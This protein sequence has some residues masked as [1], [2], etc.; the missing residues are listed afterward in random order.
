MG[1]SMRPIRELVPLHPGSVDPRLSTSYE[2]SYHVTSGD[3]VQQILGPTQ[4]FNVRGPARDF[5]KGDSPVNDCAQAIALEIMAERF[6]ASFFQNGALPLLIF[7]FMEGTPGFES[8]EQ[9]KQF[10]EDFQKA[11]SGK[12]VHRGML[13]PKGFEKPETVAFEHDR[14]QFLETRQY[15]RTVIAGAFGVPPTILGALENAHYNNVEQMDKDFTINVVM[16]IVRAFESSMERDLLTDSDRNSGIVIRFNMDATLRA[17]FRSRQEGL[18]LQ[19]Q[20]GVVSANEWREIEGRNP[21]DDEE[22]DDYLHPGNMVVDGEE[23]NE[24][25]PNDSVG[26]QEPE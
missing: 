6:G 25:I 20:A 15:Q 13:L 14:A 23:M 12:K 19:R 3:G 2:P 24:Q 16:P 4:L 7:R 21:R 11:F 5:I 1:V 26:N 8:V 22:G 10:M 18:W 9:E 17:D